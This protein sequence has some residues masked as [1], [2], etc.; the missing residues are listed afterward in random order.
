L[1]TAKESLT[2][3]EAESAIAA[4][5]PGGKFVA[6]AKSFIPQKH[7]RVRSKMLMNFIISIFLKNTDLKRFFVSR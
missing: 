6:W 1:A 5:S 4:E 7:I 2:I 3:T